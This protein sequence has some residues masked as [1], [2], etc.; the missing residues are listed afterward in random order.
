MRLALKIS[1]ALVWAFM[2]LVCIL[3]VSIL[4]LGIAEAFLT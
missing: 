1:L 4:V 3:G 2:W